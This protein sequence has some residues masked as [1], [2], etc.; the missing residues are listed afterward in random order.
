MI[1]NIV[2]KRRRRRRFNAKANSLTNVENRERYIELQEH[3]LDKYNVFLQKRCL[4]TTIL[5][6]LEKNCY[7]LFVLR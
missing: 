7:E 5:D 3:L 2:N 6:L 4:N 1:R